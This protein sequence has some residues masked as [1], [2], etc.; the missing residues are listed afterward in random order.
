MALEAASKIVIAVLTYRRNEDLARLLPELVRQA[1][2]Q[3]HVVTTIVID[4]DPDGCARDVVG[5][6]PDPLVSYVHEPKS[7]IVAARNRALISAADAAILVFIDDDEFPSPQ[8]LDHLLRTF[9]EFPCSGVTGPVLRTHDAAPSAVVREARVFDRIRHPTG[10][11]LPAAGTGNLLLD[12]AAVRAAG[13][14]FDER[15]AVTGG[16]DTLFTRRLVQ[17]AGEIVWC[18]EAVVTER[19]PAQRLTMGWVFRRSIRSGITWAR[20][21]VALGDSS[22]LRF[23]I[24]LAMTTKGLVRVLGGSA[25]WLL[26][27]IL[28]NA[29]HQGRGMRTLGRGIGHIAG[30][31]GVVYQEYRRTAPVEAA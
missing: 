20:T 16:S 15:Y 10:T 4:N 28:Q 12:L 18:D 19:V 29:E 25:R 3:L 13:L 26:G 30:S 6:N 5:S 21:S 1:G 11:R 23:S 2:L 14:F 22:L 24:R 8:W 31:F 7:G 27:V 17:S 9:D